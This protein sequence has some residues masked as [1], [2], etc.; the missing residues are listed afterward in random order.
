M[1]DPAGRRGGRF[2]AFDPKLQRHAVASA[3]SSQKPLP[4]RILSRYGASHVS[5]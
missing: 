4:G 1:R 5:S 3:S 2:H